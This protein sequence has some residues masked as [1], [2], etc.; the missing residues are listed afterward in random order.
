M[1]KKKK[2]VNL[3]GNRD[4]RSN[5]STTPADRRDSNLGERVTDFLTS[6]VQKI[7]YRIPLG[8][9]TSLGLVNFPHKI[10]TRFLITLENNLNR[11]F[12]QTQNLTTYQ[13]NHARRSHFMIHHTSLIHK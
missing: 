7:Y 11:L 1:K 13:T 10:D 5:T 8:L 12:K 2:A 9:F 3:N 4:R 6:I